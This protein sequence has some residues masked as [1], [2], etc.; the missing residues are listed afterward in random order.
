MCKVDW[1]MKKWLPEVSQTE[2]HAQLL[3]RFIR[4][5]QFKDNMVQFLFQ[6]FWYSIIIIHNI[7]NAYLWIFENSLYMY[8]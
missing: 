5:S 8:M 6:I 4:V 2:R 1:K 3:I 7:K